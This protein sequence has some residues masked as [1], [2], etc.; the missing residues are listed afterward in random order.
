MDCWAITGNTSLSFHSL[1]CPGD[2]IP[3][4]S[5]SPID[6][7]LP[8]QLTGEVKGKSSL[9]VLA[10]VLSISH[11]VNLC[12]PIAVSF[13]FSNENPSPYPYTTSFLSSSILV[14]KQILSPALCTES[15]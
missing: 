13:P 2:A 10:L 6:V 15:G 12:S 14:I 4:L 1:I 3:S 8:S 9:T 7:F 11:I 5:P